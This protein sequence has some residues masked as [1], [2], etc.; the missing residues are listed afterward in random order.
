MLTKPAREF[1]YTRPVFRSNIP[2]FLPYCSYGRELGSSPH[3]FLL[4]EAKGCN[5][6]HRVFPSYLFSKGQHMAPL[7]AYGNRNARNG[8]LGRQEKHCLILLY[9]QISL[10]ALHP[11]GLTRFSLQLCYTGMS[12]V[13]L[14]CWNQKPPFFFEKIKIDTNVKH[15]IFK[16]GHSLPFRFWRSSV[17]WLH[18]LGK[19]H[20]WHIKTHDE[21]TW[22]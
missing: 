14:K 11:E 9:I 21:T 3:S 1:G 22:F 8:V 4:W 6:E 12:Y 15:Q 13:I 17:M 20:S 7:C 18:F 2:S 16:H 5:T 19:F 10:K